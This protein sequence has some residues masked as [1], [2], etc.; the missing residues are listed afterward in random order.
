M[1]FDNSSLLISIYKE[2]ANI[3]LG[4][5]IINAKVSFIACRFVEM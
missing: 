3:R 1:E 4:T 5:A 2:Y